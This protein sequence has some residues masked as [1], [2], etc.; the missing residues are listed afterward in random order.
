[1]SITLLPQETAVV[2]LS[3]H[4][5][6]LSTDST[7]LQKLH[8]DLIPVLDKNVKGNKNAPRRTRNQSTNQPE[9]KVPMKSGLQEVSL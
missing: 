7:A 2:H 5:H 8:D 4:R 1:M 9:N 6:G 3:S